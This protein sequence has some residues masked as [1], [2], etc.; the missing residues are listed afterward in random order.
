MTEFTDAVASA[1]LVDHHVHGALRRSPTRARF[2]AMINEGFPG[3]P[4]AG[5]NPFDSQ[6]GFALRRWCAPLLG[7]EPGADAE[8]YW[9]AR[10]A[11]PEPE[12]NRLL[13]PSAGVSDWLIDTGYRGDE[14]LGVGE[15]AD[16]GGRTRE[17][18]RLETVAETLASGGAAPRDYADA[19]RQA[20]AEATAGPGVVGVKSIIAYRSGFDIDL[21]RPT[22][23][24]VAAA[25]AVWL[26][27]PGE[28]PRLDDPVLLRFGL[29]T[30]L[31]RGLPIQLHVG[32]GDRDADLLRVNPLQLRPFLFA[33][34]AAGVPVLLLHCY[35]YEREA[36]VLA[37]SFGTVYLDVGEAVNYVGARSPAL[38]AA[39]LELAPFSRVLYS[40]DAWGPAE[41]HHLGAR[42]WRRGFTEVVSRWIEN[43]D[44]TERD[45]IRVHGLIASENARAVYGL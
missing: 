4:L 5:M 32:F 37:Q 13:L 36:G 2:E 28:H 33:A 45:A 15:M 41:L 14:I 8:D 10:T 24:E 19:Y 34:E 3:T 9:A 44:W 40:S 6:L 38:I 16:F 23:A 7:L 17:I 21:S 42:L 18:V 39:A 30:A 1:P 20:V 43:G 11:V 35:P 25:A 29:Y 26:A 22:D 31:D 27:E 12:L